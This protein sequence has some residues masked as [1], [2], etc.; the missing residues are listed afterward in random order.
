MFER[1]PWVTVEEYLATERVSE[2]R[3]EYFDGDV[4]AMTPAPSEH[5]L[6]GANVSCELSGALRTKPCRVYGG[7]QRVKVAATGLYTYPDVTVVCGGPEF[8]DDSRTT[9]LNPVVIVEVLSESTEAYDRGV[10]FAHYLRLDSLREYVLIASHRRRI[11]R[12]TRQP[13][14]QE[15]FY[16]SCGEPDGSLTLPSV[17]C[18]LTMAE[19]YLNVD[20]PEGEPGTRRGPV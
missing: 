14:A 6:I 7:N 15:W 5:N 2:V 10:K 19:V 12:F 11:E 3:H 8:D 9:V 18:V 13:G 20:L 16:A 1:R 4:F 17:G